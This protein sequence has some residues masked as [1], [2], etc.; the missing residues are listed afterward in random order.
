[1]ILLRGY[2]DFSRRDISVCRRLHKFNKD[3][4]LLFASMA[5][6][7]RR[8]FSWRPRLYARFLARRASRRKRIDFDAPSVRKLK[9]PEISVKLLKHKLL[10]RSKSS[11]CF[12]ANRSSMMET[13]E[14]VN[15]FAKD[16]R[17]QQRSLGRQ[18]ICH[19][20]QSSWT[21]RSN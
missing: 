15:M 1:M 21:Q 18:V 4:L 20:M 12:A 7:K 10:S 19:R 5:G 2:I 8:M 16:H 6:D 9:S 13:H 17:Q 14:R 3:M 11:P